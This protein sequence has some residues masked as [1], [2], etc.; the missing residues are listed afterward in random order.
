ME[1]RRPVRRTEAASTNG[2]AMG[3]AERIRAEPCKDPW[4][5]EILSERTVST[6]PWTASNLQLHKADAMFLDEAF[7]LAKKEARRSNRI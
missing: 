7:A 5:I 6:E 3:I 4:S 1:I 2:L